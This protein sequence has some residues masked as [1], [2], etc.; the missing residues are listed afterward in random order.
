[1]AHKPENPR[2]Y[3][4]QST[5]KGSNHS[6]EKMVSAS[7]QQRLESMTSRLRLLES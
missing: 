4:I 2:A 3:L 1:M 7:R 6:R 5:S